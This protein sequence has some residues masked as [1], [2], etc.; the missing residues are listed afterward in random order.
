MSVVASPVDA[1][2]ESANPG[3]NRLMV[4]PMFAG[5]LASAGIDTLDDLFGLTGGERLNKAT[6]PSWRERLRVS[7][8]G[9]GTC[10]LK[11]YSSPPAAVQVRR[12]LSGHLN[13]STARIEW[14]QI[15][16][17]ET[18]GIDSVRWVAFGEELAGPWEQRSAVLTAELPG[19]SLERYV[20][21]CPGRVARGWGHSL[22]EF[23]A[24]FHGA[25]YVHRDL[26]LSHV[27]VDVAERKPVFRLIDLARVMK[28]WLRRRRWI[29]KDLA[30]LD[31]STPAVFATAADRLRFL[32][33]YLGVEHLGPRDRRLVRQIARKTRRIARHDAR[34]RGASRTSSCT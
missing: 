7:L 1:S 30:A 24:R 33:T 21:R 3:A 15:R 5:A 10:Y 12:M 2:P 17:L 27:F 4:A 20:E 32:Q 19:E 29:V 9:V 22:A 23:V 26:Y 14:N 8:P 16:R 11:R 28:P 18:D 6:L 25:G 34:L 31:Y 13:Q